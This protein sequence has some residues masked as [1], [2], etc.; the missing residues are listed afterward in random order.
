MSSNQKFIDKEVAA[1]GPHA[2]IGRMLQTMTVPEAHMLLHTA[3][4]HLPSHV[5]Q[6][7]LRDVLNRVRVEELSL[8]AAP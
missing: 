2:L 7:I 1:H 5:A 3:A 4:Q 6:S 8:R